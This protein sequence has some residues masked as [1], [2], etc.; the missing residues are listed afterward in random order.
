MG[1]KGVLF[2]LGGVLFT[3]GEA[4]YRRE[5]ARRLGLGE[6]LPPAYEERIAELQRGE[7]DEVDLWEE[8]SGRRVSPRLFDDAWLGHFHPRPS[9]FDLAREL[10]SLGM[11]TG[12]LSNTQA[13]HVSCMRRL[14]LFEGFDPVVM[15]CEAGHRKPEPEVFQVAVARM[16]LQP[17][18]VVFVD[19]VPAYVEAARQAGLQAL[20]HYGDVAAT[21]SEILALV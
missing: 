5:V 11:R 14:D 9:M 6:E 8:L 19:D 4:A 17:G 16:G 7:L 21:R 18:E 12:I 3:L 2:D 15:S 10:R 1:I 20:L 13:S